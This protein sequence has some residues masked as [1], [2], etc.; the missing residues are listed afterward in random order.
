M[1]CPA[2]HATLLSATGLSVERVVPRPGAVTLCDQCFCWC[3]FEARV[4]PRPGLGLRRATPDEIEAIDPVFRE[5][6]R[7]L[8]AFIAGASE[9]RE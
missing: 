8:A 1:L 6:A 5:L 3:V 2:C 9:D 4:F 7:E